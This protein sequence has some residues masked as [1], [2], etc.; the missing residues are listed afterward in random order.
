MVLIVFLQQKVNVFVNQPLHFPHGVGRNAAVPGQSN[1]VQPELAL[2]V[3]AA[4]VNVR[5]L[6]TLVR[7]KVE[8]ITTDSQHCGQLFRVLP[9]RD[10]GEFGTG[11]GNR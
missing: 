2:S 5:R 8:T 11:R 7:I 9:A 10:A 4:H 1:R 3:C 6:G